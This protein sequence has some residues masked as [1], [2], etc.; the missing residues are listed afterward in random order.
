MQYQ[1][2]FNTQLALDTAFLNGAAGATGTAAYQLNIN[3]STPN[4]YPEV[5]TFGPDNYPSVVPQVTNGTWNNGNLII[6]DPSVDVTITW[7]AFVATNSGGGGI[8]FGI[9]NNSGFN[10]FQVIDAD[11]THN[12]YTIA[13]GT[14][15]NNS[16]YNGSLQFTNNDTGS[17]TSFQA[18]VNFTIQV[19]T[20]PDV[21]NYEVQKQENY[22]QASSAAPRLIPGIRS[23]FPATSIR[24]TTKRVG[25][26]EQFRR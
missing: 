3:T 25:P 13:G 16:Y 26:A 2:S 7:P 20:P 19:G 4:S 8:S 6:T 15:T 23:N 22:D 1:A 11:G 18:Q 17:P 10:L 12:S 24:L 21:S 5:F 14:L 9:T